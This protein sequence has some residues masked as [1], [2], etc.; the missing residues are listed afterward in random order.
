MTVR[1]IYK[2][3]ILKSDEEISIIIEANAIQIPVEVR[4]EIQK[5]RKSNTLNFILLKSDELRSSCR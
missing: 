3:C 5:Q 4:E 1:E 2:V